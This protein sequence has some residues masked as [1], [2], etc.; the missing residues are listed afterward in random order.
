M[1]AFQGF[2]QL[3]HYNQVFTLID[4]RGNCGNCSDNCG[5]LRPCVVCGKQLCAECWGFDQI[6]PECPRCEE[7]YQAKM[8]VCHE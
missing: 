1:H 3:R 4:L 7:N 6:S 2:D 8:E 5:E